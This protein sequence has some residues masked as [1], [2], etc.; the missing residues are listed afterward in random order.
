[1]YSK[2][3]IVEILN[4]PENVFNRDIVP[5]SQ[6]VAKDT[7]HDSLLVTSMMG[8]S[9]ICKNNCL[10]CGMRAKNNPIPRFRIAP[11]EVVAK[12]LEAKSQGFQRTFLIS[13]ED[14]KYGFENILHIVHRLKQEGMFISLACGEFEPSQFDELKSAGVDQYVLKFEMSDP[15]SFNRL[16]PSTN[17]NKRMKSIEYVRTLGLKLASGNI[18]DWPGQTVEELTDDILLMKELEISWAPI[19]PYLP[20]KHTPLA[21]SGTR[22]DLLKLYKEI[23]ILRLLM[24]NVNITAQQPGKDMA[25][26]LSD[27]DGNLEAIRVGANVLFFDL[28]A[29]AQAKSFRVIDDRNITGPSHIFQIAEASDKS[30]IV[31]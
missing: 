29:D 18:V 7:L 31:K 23:A 3:E 28:L 26:G 14:P 12:C 9:N 27:L 5:L 19:I 17:F 8:Y 20:A 30:L 6:K 11:D 21:E 2:Q 13:G 16:N 24:P 1:M 25:K 10:Y 4:M 15:E 22:G